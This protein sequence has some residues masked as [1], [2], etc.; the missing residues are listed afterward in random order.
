MKINN[1]VKLSALFI[2]M[3]SMIYS[4]YDTNKIA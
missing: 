1:E 3:N 2:A 4:E